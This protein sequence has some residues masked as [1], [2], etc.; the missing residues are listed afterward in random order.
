MI[1]IDVGSRYLATVSTLD[2]GA[3]FYSRRGDTCQGGPLRESAKAI[4]AKRHSQ[5]HTAQNR[6]RPARET[7]QAA[8]Q[9]A[10]S[11]RILDSH[12]QAFIGVEDLTGIRERTK[13]R[14][15][16]RKGKQLIPLSKRARKANRHAS[17]WSF[18]ELQGLLTYKAALAGVCA[19]KWMR[20]T[21]AKPA[22]VVGTPAAR[23][24]RSK[25]CS[26][27]ARVV[28]TRSTRI[29]WVPEILRCARWSSS[30]TG[31]PRGGCQ[32]PLM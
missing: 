15:R 20:T 1:G 28:S 10:I 25:G 6:A 18:A 8:H 22:R 14:T 19:S 21:P 17:K 2:N 24:G 26:L 16:R 4:A 9:P 13:R 11:K 12:P 5:C 31:W 27:S 29:W 3:Q 23:T 30:K 32:T 7:V